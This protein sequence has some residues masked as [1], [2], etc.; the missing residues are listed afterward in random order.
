MKT[1]TKIQAII[2]FVAVGLVFALGTVF[3]FVPMQFGSKDYES[4]LRAI[5]V[6]QE[7]ANGV[8][9]VYTVEGEDIT[10]EQMDK[11]VDQIS[12]IV[13]SDGYQNVYVSQVGENSVRVDIRESLLAQTTSETIESLKAVTSGQLVLST[14]SKFETEST[15]N[16]PVWKINGW[17]H[18][19]SVEI[20][21]S[22]GVYGVQINLNKEGKRIYEEAYCNW[23]WSWYPSA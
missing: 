15:E 6:S 3:A 10:Q 2:T 8:S 18:I 12:S 9:A 7:L 19:D 17:E 16:A 4:F 22:Q 23:Q 13:K 20:I 1:L 14:G 11:V 21:Q 5:P